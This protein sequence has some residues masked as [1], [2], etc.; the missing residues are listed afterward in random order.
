VSQARLR[1]AFLL[2]L[3]VMTAHEAEH[4]AQVVQKDAIDAAC[5]ND[6]RGLLGFLF[7]V[8]PIHF[9]Y[10]VSIFVALAALY[11][12]GGLWRVERLPREKLWGWLSL[13]VGIFVVQADHVIEHSEKFAQWLGN[14]HRDGT[15]GFLGKLL[16]PPR[17]HNFSL[18]ELHFLF[19]TVVFVAVV[20]GYFG[21]GLHRGVGV[22]GRRLATAFAL[23]TTAFIA[24][25]WTYRPPTIHLD[26]GIHR[27]PIV[28]D[29]A[30]RLVGAPGAVVRGGI[31]IRA[32][33]VVVRDVT[34]VGGENGIEIDGAKD[35]LL[36][37]VRIR[38]ARLDGI[39]ARLSVVTIRNCTI[40][41]PSGFTQ[42]IDI[43]FA[44]HLGMSMVV[45]CTVIGGREGIVID[46]ADAVVRGNRVS[47][48]AMRGISLNEMSMTMVEHNE[49]AGALGVGIF[50]GD[51]SECMIEDNRVSGTRADRA[52]GD[53]ALQGYGIQSHYRS[54]AELSGNEL[55]GNAHG[56]GSFAGAEIVH[57]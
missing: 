54:R 15:P 32:D 53:L 48:T 44:T 25:A 4:V 41:S 28:L 5:P 11:V 51:Q 21:L 29:R 52:S 56:M 34:V 37:R 9:A 2:L 38:G 36:E 40:E 42:G 27:G 23:G 35:V 47:A 33:D 24:V 1:T 6:C 18:I 13:T 12:G 20:A 31:R 26:A 17:G 57:R 16:P 39:H 3:V 30:E 7:D 50:C 8:E 43:S 55:V 14:G 46:S 45:G 49:I 19:N 22:A 10:N